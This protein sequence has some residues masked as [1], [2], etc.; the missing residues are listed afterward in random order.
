MGSKKEESD[1]FLG[2]KL[3]GLGG[4]LGTVPAP[5]T[6]QTC[7]VPECGHV[8][9]ANRPRKRHSGARGAGMKAMPIQWER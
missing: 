4:W 8:S 5:Y 3:H 7:P 1:T 2:Y 6:S 9:Q